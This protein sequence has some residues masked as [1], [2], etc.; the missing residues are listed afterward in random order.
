M[1]ELDE[2]FKSTLARIGAQDVSHIKMVARFSIVCEIIGRGLIHFSFEPILFSLGV[3]VLAIHKQLEVTELGHNIQHG[4]Y[5]KVPGAEAYTPKGHWWRF[6][7]RVPV[8]APSWR[9]SHNQL[10]HYYTNVVGKDPDARLYLRR[11]EDTP[12]EWRHRLLFLETALNWPNI[13]F[14]ANL[15]ATGLFEVYTRDAQELEVLTD[16]SK[17]SIV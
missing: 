11:K 13:L 1:T 17:K 14:N 16:K 2:L 3:F 15:M 9:Y 6:H 8:H 5:E 7:Q 12:F 10:H 4:T